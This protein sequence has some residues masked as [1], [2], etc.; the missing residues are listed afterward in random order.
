MSNDNN[1]VLLT[2]FVLT[3][4]YLFKANILWKTK[5]FNRRINTEEKDSFFLLNHYECHVEI[6]KAQDSF[7]FAS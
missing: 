6:D 2:L 7:L 4:S 1:N 3:F 5:V